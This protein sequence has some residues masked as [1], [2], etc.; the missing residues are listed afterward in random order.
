MKV[1]VEEYGKVILHALLGIIVLTMSYGLFSTQFAGNLNTQLNSYN[2]VQADTNIEY[3][4]KAR[5][6]LSV[7]DSVKINV[8]DTFDVISTPA[9]NIID[10]GTGTN[11]TSQVMI[12]GEICDVKYSG[13]DWIENKSF[14]A[15]KEGVYLLRYSIRDSQ[16]FY[17]SNKI[18]VI[19]EP[20]AS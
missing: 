6:T 11:I 5:P 10:G 1:F 13:S 4:S 18:Q 8:G 3:I 20:N 15:E 14:K 19:V 12:F 7:N 2:T 16:G 17:A 9:L